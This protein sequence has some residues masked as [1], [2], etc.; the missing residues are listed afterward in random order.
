[1]TCGY[2]VIVA[3]RERPRCGKWLPRAKVNC[4]LPE[5]HAGRCRTPAGM[6]KN[7]DCNITRLREAAAERYK[8]VDAYK[9]ERGCVD[10]GYS[11][12]PRALDFDHIRDVK[13]AN[14]SELVRHAPW[15]KVLTEIT[16]CVVRCANCHRVKTF[17]GQQEAGPAATL[18]DDDGTP[19][20]G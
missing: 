11:A 3:S 12:D 16:K 7:Y 10:C 17:R 19:A 9:V 5:N 8:W 13:V 18:S 6:R 1:M 15:H 4:P 20:S 2:S 14:V